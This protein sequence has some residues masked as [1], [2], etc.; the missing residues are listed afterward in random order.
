MTG[1]THRNVDIAELDKQSYLHPFTNVMDH[2]RTGP[3]MIESGDGIWIT[4]AKGQTYIDA[5]SGLICVNVGYGREEIAKA[6]YDQARKLCYFHTFWATGNEPAARLADRIVEITPPNMRRVMFGTSGS[7][8][9]DTQIK[10]SWYY[11]NVLGRPQKKKI[12]ARERGYHG[13]TLGAASV[14]GMPALHKM[15]DLPIPQVIWASAPDYGKKAKPGMSERDFSISLAA[16]LE[17]LVEAE[18][19]DTVAAFIGEPVM[20]SSSGVLVPPEGYFEEIGKVLRKHDILFIADEV[21]NGFGRVGD[22]F[23]SNLYGLEPDLMTLSK[24]LTSGYVPMS[25]AVVSEKV[26]QVLQ[27]GSEEFGT[28]EHGYTNSGHPVAAAAA[29]ANLDIIE[30]ENLVENA[31]RVG[32]YLQKSL[33]ETIGAYAEVKEIRGIGL[34][35]G[36]E[37]FERDEKAVAADPTEGLP[38]RIMRQCYEEGLIIRAIPGNR[39]V[40]VA[41]P[42]VITEQQVDDV[43]ERLERGLR[44]VCGGPVRQAKVAAL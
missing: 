35:A 43:I 34:I 42:L 10:L 11:N 6:I 31:A 5:T 16:E 23:A 27:R 9:N 15:F 29:L 14:T 28:F 22:M 1:Q 4:D 32:A 2:Q 12:I 8:A 3:W 20:G 13:T 37:F 19:P 44:K 40:V 41:P 38:V 39:T 26:W 24:G 21:V 25:A 33:R 18:G 30:R 36:I 7:D 17:A